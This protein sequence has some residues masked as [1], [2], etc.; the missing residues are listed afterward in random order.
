MKLNEYVMCYV[1]CSR[2]VH[3]F[4]TDR[5]TSAFHHVVSDES[6]VS[7][8]LHTAR[9]PGPCSRPVNTGVQNDGP[10]FRAVNGRRV[11]CAVPNSFYVDY[12]FAFDPFFVF[13]LC[14]AS[15]SVV[16]FS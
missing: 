15:D 12:C 13:L 3:P 16:Y 14:R 6:S 9:I 4:G 2:P 8:S 5:N 7:E 10:C 11:A 1:I